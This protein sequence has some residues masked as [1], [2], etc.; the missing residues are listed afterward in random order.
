MEGNEAA[1]WLAKERADLDGGAMA[2]ITAATVRQEK[3]EVHAKYA[4]S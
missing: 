2:T 1:D 3:M 4:S